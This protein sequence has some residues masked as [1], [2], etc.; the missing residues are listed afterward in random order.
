LEKI[1]LVQLAV[2]NPGGNDREQA[3]PDFAGTPD[4]M[5][6]HPPVNYHA[7][8]ACTGGTFYREAARIPPERRAVLL[9]LRRDLKACLKALKALNALNALEALGKL[10]GEGSRVAVSLKESGLHQ[11]S[12]LLGNAENMALFREICGVADGC[13]ASTQE[14]VALYAAAGGKMVRFIPTPYPIEAEKWNFALPQAQRSG[15]FIGTREWDVPSRNHAA[16]LLLAGRLGAAV[17]VVNEEGQAG[18]KRLAAAGI[19]GLQI[20][21]GRRPYAEY[22][23][24]IARHRIV[25]QLDRSAVPGQVAGDAL[26]CGVPCVGG[27]GAIERIAFPELC[28]FG[29][30]FEELGEI[31]S[32]LLRD[33]EAYAEAARRSRELALERLSFGAVSRLLGEYFDALRATHDPTR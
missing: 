4:D 31:A 28:G 2:L 21:E 13:V 3:F 19:P 26:L 24:L 7:Y 27:D 5:A 18:R 17:T 11:V 1:A 8:A 9:V 32:G 20:I 25:L 30:G 6:A 12:E 10:K 14:M 33:D 15:V 16:A 22:L 23:R 29:R